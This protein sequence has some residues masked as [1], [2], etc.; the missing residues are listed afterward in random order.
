MTK[1]TDLVKHQLDDIMK[2]K[3][4]YNVKNVRRREATEHQRHMQHVS[5]KHELHLTKTKLQRKQRELEKANPA[6]RESATRSSDAVREVSVFF[7]QLHVIRVIIGGR[8]ASCVY[9]F[10]PG[11]TKAIYIDLGRPCELR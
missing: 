3:G 9:A 11:K 10:F 8:C 5:L 6:E 4:Y 1:T 7:R 2:R